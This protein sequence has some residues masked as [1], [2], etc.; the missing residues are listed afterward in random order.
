VPRAQESVQVSVDRE[1]AAGDS[2]QGGGVAADPA[3][4]VGHE[5]LAGESLRAVPG[6]QLGRGL[7]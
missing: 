4:Q 5:A 2:G 6:G 1:D 3:A 7:L